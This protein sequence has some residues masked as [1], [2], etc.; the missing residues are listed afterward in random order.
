MKVVVC[1]IL[2]AALSVTALFSI[3]QAGAEEMREIPSSYLHLIADGT[4]KKVI[5]PSAGRP[6]NKKTPGQSQ[7]LK[8]I[9]ESC[10]SVNVGCGV[11]ECKINNNG[12]ICEGTVVPIIEGAPIGTACRASC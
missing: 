7:S 4:S 1:S 3:T 8:E 9:E 6:G 12:T 5:V 2:V 11:S 10:S